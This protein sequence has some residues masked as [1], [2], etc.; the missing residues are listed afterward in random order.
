MQ[1]VFHPGIDLNLGL[2]KMLFYRWLL[3][4]PMLVITQVIGNVWQLETNA[5]LRAPTDIYVPFLIYILNLCLFKRHFRFSFA[6]SANS[7]FQ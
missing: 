5:S 6:L 7:L 1:S 2:L 4:L 3:A